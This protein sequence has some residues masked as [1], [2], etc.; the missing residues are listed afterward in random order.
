M[1]LFS[2]KHTSQTFSIFMYS[3][4]IVLIHELLLVYNVVE[5]S[6]SLSLSCNSKFLVLVLHKS[7]EL[8]M[9]WFSLSLP[10]TF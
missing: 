10:R 3:F 2:E 9:N 5:V 6:L 8:C 4:T 7:A 1:D